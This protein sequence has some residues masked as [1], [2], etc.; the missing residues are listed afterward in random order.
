MEPKVGQTYESPSGLAMKVV[1]KEGDDLHV[2]VDRVVRKKDGRRE[3]EVRKRV[4]PMKL[5]HWFSQNYK[6]EAKK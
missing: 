5:W 2:E 3:I 6:P 4:V 1:S